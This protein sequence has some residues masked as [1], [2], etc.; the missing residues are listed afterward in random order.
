[1]Y[2][3]EDVVLDLRFNYLNMTFPDIQIQWPDGSISFAS[4]GDDWLNEARKSGINIPTGCMTGSC[5][6]CEIE[7]NGKVLRACVTT[8]SKTKSK[9]LPLANGQL[10]LVEKVCFVCVCV[11]FPFFLFSDF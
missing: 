5:G 6:A 10:S 7:V 1:M 11:F 3:D 2:L 8:I 9:K 4:D